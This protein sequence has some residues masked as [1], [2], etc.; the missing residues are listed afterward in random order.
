[1]SKV[2]KLILKTKIEAKGFYMERSNKIVG[3]FWLHR[4]S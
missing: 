4:N 3:I 1:M 2:E